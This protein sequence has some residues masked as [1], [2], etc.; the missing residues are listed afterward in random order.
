MLDYTEGKAA[1]RYD[2]A[3]FDFAGLVLGAV[4]ARSEAEG[5]AP[6]RR[7]EDIHEASGIGGNVEAYRQVCFSLFRTAPFQALFRRLGA[8]LIDSHFGGTGLIQKTPT[9]RI[10][11]PGTSSTS[12]HSDGWYGHGASVRSFWLPL[13]EV[14]PGNTLHMARSIAE[15]RACM[16][17]ILAEKASLGEINAMA[18]EVCEPFTGGPGDM[19]TFSSAMI[20]GTET[21]SWN[22]SRVSFDFRIAPDARDLG[23]KPRSN[24]YSRAELDTDGKSGAGAVPGR[25]AP[26]SGITYSNACNGISAKAQLMLC[27]A[28]ADA[29]GFSITGSEAEIAALDYLPV[30]RSYLSGEGGAAGCVVAFG[31]DIFEG[32]MALAGQILDCADAGG[33]ALIFCAEGLHFEPGGDRAPVLAAIRPAR[34]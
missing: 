18:R 14:G 8:E 25:A 3:R 22:Q 33:T 34:G 32:D 5:G 6:V 16:A 20:H 4:S 7:L 2:T 26:R 24:F 19:L 29:N 13:T 15:S 30:L 27:T 31:T 12:Y 10:Q 9:V 11:L 28:Y 23:S 1:L 17:A 21:N